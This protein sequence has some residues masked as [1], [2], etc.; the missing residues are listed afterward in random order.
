MQTW[1]AMLV[2]TPGVAENLSR[3]HLQR[4]KPAEGGV[5]F[6]STFASSRSRC[7]LPGVVMIHIIHSI[8]GPRSLR[9]L[10]SA[11]WLPSPRIKSNR[12]TFT[13][14]PT[15]SIVPTHTLFFPFSVIFLLCAPKMCHDANKIDGYACTLVVCCIVRRSGLAFHQCCD[16]SR[17]SFVCVGCRF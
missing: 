4:D 14:L 15:R 8:R 2:G 13:L 5:R 7:V 12:R 17:G 6:V 16:R 10:F 11:R 1:G 3:F 9:I